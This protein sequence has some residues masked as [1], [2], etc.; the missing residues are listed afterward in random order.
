MN[1]IIS[2][3]ELPNNETYNLKD[4]NALSKSGGE[5][6]K[7]AVISYPVGN[8]Q[9]GVT[10]NGKAGNVKLFTETASNGSLNLIVQFTN[11]NNDGF[12]IRNSEGEDIAKVKPDGEF[13]G[14]I[15]W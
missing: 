15:D 11:D 5:M 13:T 1:N 7:D 3:I 10:W 6:Q 14:T 12:I 8:S 4:D 2:K 9:G